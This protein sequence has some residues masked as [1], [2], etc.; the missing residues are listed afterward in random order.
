M[1]VFVGAN[2]GNQTLA[3]GGDSVLDTGH[4]VFHRD[5][6]AGIACASC[7]AEGAEDGHVWNFST[8]GARRTQA[9]NVGLE[10][11]E[12]FH[13]SGDMP[14]LSVLVSEVFVRRMGGAQQSADRMSALSGWLFAQQPSAPL[15]AVDD[16]AAQR[17][18]ALFNAPEV[19]RNSCHSGEKLTNNESVDVGTGERF[20]VPSLVGI[21]Y[22]APCLHTGCAP[23]LRDRFTDTACGGGDQHGHT[24]QLTGDQIDDLVAYLETL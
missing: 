21:A 9:I 17:G 20:Q 1:L 12:P 6:G 5:A 10:G 3:L 16:A 2:G 15:R 8:F 23:T 14:E 18:H 7:H 11:T 19:G 24:S 4:E 13:W 22:R